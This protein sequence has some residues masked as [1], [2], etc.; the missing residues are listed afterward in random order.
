M[1][2]LRSTSASSSLHKLTPFAKGVRKDEL[3]PIATP[4]IRGS[5]ETPNSEAVAKPIGIITS[6]DDVLEI[7]CVMTADT[8]KIPASTANGPALPSAL[9]T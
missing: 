4:I 1:I 8:R 5:A 6:A 9:T 2:V 7:T 3:A